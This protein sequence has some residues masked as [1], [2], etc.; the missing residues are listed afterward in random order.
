MPLPLP[1]PRSGFDSIGTRA[2][3]RLAAPLQAVA[4]SQATS[5]P[6]LA[7]ATLLGTAS[8][9]NGL[10]STRDRVSFYRP[11]NAD[12]LHRRPSFPCIL[13]KLWIRGLGRM[14]NGGREAKQKDSGRV[15]IGIGEPGRI[16][17]DCR[18]G[19]PSPYRRRASLTP[20]EARCHL[21]GIKC[22]LK[23]VSLSSSLQTDEERASQ[24]P[25]KRRKGGARFCAPPFRPPCAFEQPKADHPGKNPAG[26]FATPRSP[27][28]SLRCSPD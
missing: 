26:F 6:N 24:P 19:V 2:L 10:P 25:L 16:A 23:G 8:E 7:A 3:R 28:R 9:T 27:P 22:L 20:E 18:N 21:A 1:D 4:V 13:V 5:Q 11:W 17:D 12:A 14:H 15:L